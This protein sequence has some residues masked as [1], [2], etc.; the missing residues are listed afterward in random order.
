MGK[1]DLAKK[2]G[3]Q[4]KQLGEKYVIRRIFQKTEP[5]T[6][7]ELLY[8]VDYL[9]KHT[10]M[11]KEPFWLALNLHQKKEVANAMQFHSVKKGHVMTIAL[12]QEKNFPAK[13][14][15]L[16]GQGRARMN[17]GASKKKLDELEKARLKEKNRVK[18][19]KEMQQIFED[20]KKEKARLA[21]EK[22]AGITELTKKGKRVWGLARN[23]Y[24]GETQSDG[25]G[26][27]D[28]S[29]DIGNMMQ[30]IMMQQAREKGVV[31]SAVLGNLADKPIGYIAGATKKARRDSVKTSKKGK[32]LT[33]KTEL[34]AEHLDPTSVLLSEG[35][36]F[37]QIKF[38]A[39]HILDMLEE[40]MRRMNEDQDPAATGVV[41]PQGINSEPIDRNSE[42]LYAADC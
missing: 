6:E 41:P 19:H 42:E 13:Y 3:A 37:G 25:G 7:A 35:S 36:M 31:K 2:M 1:A 11:A 20:E 9:E 17:E 4:T 21:E 10:D 14:L 15:M 8:L 34:K 33:A 22:A 23:M 16:T 29:S 27:K 5:K 12:E 38:P 18:T 30:N 28:E 24:Q 32:P 26:K 39:H 40:E